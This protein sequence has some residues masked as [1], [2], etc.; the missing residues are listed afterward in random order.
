MQGSYWRRLEA[1]RKEE[2]NLGRRGYHNGWKQ[3]AT[4][5]ALPPI[6]VRDVLKAIYDLRDSD[7]TDE[8]LI[9]L[10]HLLDRILRFEDGALLEAY[11]DRVP[12]KTDYR[13][14]A[15]RLAR[16]LFAVDAVMT[17]KG[18]ATREWQQISLALG[19][20]SS[21]R[22]TEAAVGRRFGV[23]TMA[24][25]KSITKLLRLAELK[26]NGRGYNGTRF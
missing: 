17:E 1:E 20:P 16:V 13:S 22:L 9:W 14:A 6:S 11:L 23:C 19:L 8:S 4:E 18:P 21:R 26:P 10:S 12:N 24:V 5:F 2:A 7:F 25:S 15:E 3:P